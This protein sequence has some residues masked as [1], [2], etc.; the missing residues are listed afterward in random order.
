MEVINL[1]NYPKI[2]KYSLGIVYLFF[3]VF[4][5]NILYSQNYNNRKISGKDFE[6][7]LNQNS[8]KYSD[9]DSYEFQFKD[10]FGLSNPLNEVDKNINYQDLIVEFE[11]DN[12]RTLYFKKLE[13]MTN[14]NNSN[15]NETK[16]NFY[17]EKI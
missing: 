15:Q 9:Y 2:R 1:Y 3:L 10:F 7:V 14:L 12:I 5:P 4:F 8:V 17:N 16:W 11:S 6:N 13:Q